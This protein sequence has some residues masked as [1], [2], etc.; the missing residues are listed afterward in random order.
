[1]STGGDPRH[2]HDCGYWSDILGSCILT[3]EERTCGSREREVRAWQAAPR[4]GFNLFGPAAG[5][6]P[7]DSCRG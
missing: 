5:G 1:M 4:A 7:V 2:C 3:L 6:G